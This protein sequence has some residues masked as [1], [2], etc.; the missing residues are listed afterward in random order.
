MTL[1]AAIL[2]FA[3]TGIFA[4]VLGGLL[5]IGGGL[6]VVPILVLIFHFMGLPSAHSMH[7]AIGTSLGAM[8]FT[9]GSAAWSHIKRGCVE[10]SIF[11]FLLPGV[12]L[13]AIL[14]AMI[15]D[16]LPG[17]QLKLVFGILVVL[18]G[19]YFIISARLW[20]SSG[21]SRFFLRW[22]RCRWMA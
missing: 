1:F 2:A 5:G 15:A 12:V 14:G 7:V 20:A 6:I 18:M 4:G 17:K 21:G 8:I 3:A 22:R 9:S 19:G 13:G 10:W 16:Y 11:R